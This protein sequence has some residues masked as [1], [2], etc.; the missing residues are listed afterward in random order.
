MLLYVQNEN[1]EMTPAK[2][3]SS[4]IEYQQYIPLA[5]AQDVLAKVMIIIIRAPGDIQL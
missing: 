4:D 2:L 5:L 3:A 1:S